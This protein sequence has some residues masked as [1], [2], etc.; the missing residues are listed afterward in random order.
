MR[1]NLLP[2]RTQEDLVGRLYVNRYDCAKGGGFAI[3]N[4]HHILVARGWEFAM[5]NCTFDVDQELR[6]K[7]LDGAPFTSHAWVVG[8]LDF[9]ADVSLIEGMQTVSYNPRKDPVFKIKETGQAVFR[10]E[11]VLCHNPGVHLYP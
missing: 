2:N 10:A 7:F 11:R 5:K 9:D 4:K 6:Q 3:F 8:T 1:V